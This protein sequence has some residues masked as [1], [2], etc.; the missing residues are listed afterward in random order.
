M[1]RIGE[2]PSSVAGTY[3]TYELLGVVRV[4]NPAPSFVTEQVVVGFGPAPALGSG[5]VTGPPLVL[6]PA[7]PSPVP[8]TSRSTIGASALAGRRSLASPEGVASSPTFSP[9]IR[10]PVRSDEGVPAAEFD[11]GESVPSLGATSLLQA[12]PTNAK[13]RAAA[14]S[15]RLRIDDRCSDR[16]GPLDRTLRLERISV[17]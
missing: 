2:L 16:E 5:G 10:A 12:S 13:A 14:V 8:F 4:K 15:R 17:A 11:S 3:A 7:G 6:P 9:P 1:S